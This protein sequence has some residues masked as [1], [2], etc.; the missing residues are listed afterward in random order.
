MSDDLKKIE[1]TEPG[2]VKLGKTTKL[3]GTTDFVTPDEYEMYVNKLAWAK[4]AE[5]GEQGTRTPGAVMLDVDNI[6]QVLAT[7]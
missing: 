4:D 1:W 2:G 5:T 6:E 7:E 3:Q